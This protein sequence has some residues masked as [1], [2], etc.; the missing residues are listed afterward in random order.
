[1]ANERHVIHAFQALGFAR[2][3]SR[4]CAIFRRVDAHTLATI[5]ACQRDKRTRLREVESSTYPLALG[6]LGGAAMSQV[7]IERLDRAVQHDNLLTGKRLAA[8]EAAYCG[9]PLTVCEICEQ[10]SISAVELYGLV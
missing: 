9:S 1:M 8:I 6:G 2:L 7:V 10:F 3:P 4:V 5:P